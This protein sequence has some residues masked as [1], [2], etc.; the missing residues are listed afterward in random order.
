MKDTKHYKVQTKYN[1]T[2]AKNET[3][4]R[5][6]K[7]LIWNL[8]CKGALHYGDNILCGKKLIGRMIFFPP[9]P[10]HLLL[11]PEPWFPF[12][13]SRLCPRGNMKWNDWCFRP[14][15]CS[16]RLCW[17]RDNLDE[18]DEFWYESCNWRR[19][20]RSTYWPVVQ[21]AT[22]VP[23]TPPLC[24]MGKFWRLW[25]IVLYCVVVLYSVV[26]PVFHP[27]LNVLISYTFGK[28]EKSCNYF[29]CRPIRTNAS[30]CSFV[31]EYMCSL[32]IVLCYSA[33]KYNKFDWIFFKK[34]PTISL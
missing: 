2:I 1:P 12:V 3:E 25:R 32:F 24:P 27:H 31:C 28:C 15:F 7:A 21:R 18:W 13:R 34:N 26:L 8:H 33:W 6:E 17:A 14:W 10:W 19:I 11:V 30:R 23:R 5:A 29:V 9:L 22:T 20:D 4:T 16:V